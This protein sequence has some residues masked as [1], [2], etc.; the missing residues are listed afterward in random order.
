MRPA[1]KNPVDPADGIYQQETTLVGPV[2]RS[3]P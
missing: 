3:L 2:R 1:Q